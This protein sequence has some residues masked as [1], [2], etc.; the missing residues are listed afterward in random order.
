MEPQK[1]T[2]SPMVDGMTVDQMV[3]R[4]VTLQETIDEQEREVARLKTMIADTCDPGTF[5]TSSGLK[6]T[7]REPSRRI[8]MRKFREKYPPQSNPTLWELKPRSLASVIHEIGAPA[9][10]DCTVTGTRRTVTIR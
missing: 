9:L 2:P 6:V 7:V 1:T 5:V 3:A 10:A 4:I 8:D